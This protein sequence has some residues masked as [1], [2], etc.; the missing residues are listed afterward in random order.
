MLDPCGVDAMLEDLNQSNDF[1]GFVC[2]MR[3]AFVQLAG[4]VE[5]EQFPV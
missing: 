3:A 1:S 4:L 2:S 5:I